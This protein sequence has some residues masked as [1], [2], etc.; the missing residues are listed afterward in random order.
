[1]INEHYVGKSAQ[2]FYFKG[3]EYHVK[4]WKGLL[5]K[6]SSL[7]YNAHTDEFKKISSVR[8]KKK[9]YFSLNADELDIPEKIEGTVYFAEVH[10]TADQIVRICFRLVET[11]EYSVNDFKVKI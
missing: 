11:F 6:L 7:L 2:G 4:S 5:L 1:V 10:L 3:I 8:G 9:P